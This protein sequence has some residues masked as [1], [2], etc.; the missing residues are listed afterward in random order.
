MGDPGF[1]RLL[2][3]DGSARSRRCAPRSL[4]DPPT[5]D[6]L[7]RRSSP[8]TS[9][10]SSAAIPT[11]LSPGQA[12]SPPSPPARASSAF[13]SSPP[14]HRGH[15]SGRA[16]LA[17]A[18]ADVRAAGA[19][20]RDDGHRRAPL[21]VGGRRV[22]RDLAALP[23][24]A[25]AL[26]A[27]RGEL[28][29]G[30][31]PRRRCRRTPAAGGGRRPRDR[32]A[33]R[34]VGGPALGELGAELRAGRRPR[35]ARP[36]RDADGIAAVCALRREPRRLDRARS[37]CGPVS[38]GK[39]RRGGAP[40]RRA[41]PAC[42]APGGP[43]PRSSW[44]GPVVPY[45]RIGATSAGCSSST[46]RSFGEP[47][48]GPPPRRPAAT[49]TV[50]G[51]SPASSRCPGLRAEGY[52]ITIAGDGSR[53]RRGR[54]RRRGLRRG[55]ARPARACC[56][57]AGSRSARS[58]TG[59]TSPSPA[60]MLDI[61]A[62]QGADD[63]DAPGA[64]RPAR[65]VEG[66]PDPALR[67]AHLRLPRPRGRAGETRA[68]SP[69][70]EIAALDAYCPARHIELVPNQNCLGHMGR[71]LPHE[72]VPARW[73][74]RRHPTSPTGALRPRSSPPT[75]RPLALVRDLLGELL[76]NFSHDRYVQRRPR[77]AVGAAAGADRRLP[78][79]GAGA[80]RAP[81]AR[82]PRDARLGRHPRR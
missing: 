60:V 59:P 7:A 33:D 51:A 49:E 68:R 40:A 70:T 4:L 63:G 34:G 1:D 65:V 26:R 13:S 73:R 81:R 15:G 28:Q 23:P 16:L 54:R 56:T 74:W 61:V 53:A 80:A 2:G 22:P 12:S 55:D 18:E 20:V 69:P 46:A 9:P 67:R 39:R 76:P 41:A 44:V 47:A 31:R 27:G 58:A 30:R 8:R 79:V 82:R 11:S 14:E 35:R 24:R 78:R 72:R 10:R 17:A 38:L 29:H 25:G 77:R 52:A 50:A 43:A 19:C 64:G 57:T 32:D 21:P 5:E 62:R 6:E 42:A 37:R 48:A 36:R 45:A 3:T 66:Q 75:R 71:W